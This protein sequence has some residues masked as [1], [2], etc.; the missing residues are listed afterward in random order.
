MPAPSLSD[1]VLREALV[2]FHRHDGNKA[3]A[4]E[5]LGLPWQTL[6]DRVTRAQARR[7]SLVEAEELPDE[8]IPIEDVKEMMKSR[9]E[10]RWDHHK[11]KRWRKIQVHCDGP[12]G[13]MLFG[14][15][16][17]DDD[18]CNWPL[19]DDHIRLCHQP[20]IFGVNIGDTHNNWIGRLEKKYG[21]Q[22]SSKK[23]AYRLAEWLMKDAGI[24]WALWLLG[25][26][27]VWNEGARILQAMN[28]TGIAMADWG[29]QVAL[30]L[31]SGKEVRLWASHDFHGHSQWNSLHGPQKA[32]HMKDP[33]HIYACGH[34]H[35]WALHQEE[36]AS[37]A[38]TYWLARCRGYK[39]IDDYGEKLGHMPQHEGASILAVINPDS[40]TGAGFVQCYA[41]PE[42]G[43]EYLRWLR[44]RN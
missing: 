42:E 28:T 11:A 9:F 1:D 6:S 38:F 3:A 8:D 39:F 13:L 25:N 17:V 5:E 16:H 4:A 32:A 40:K 35:N 7:I 23:T 33:A 19:L 15:P 43:A 22:E 34:K 24:D 26:H 27:D 2:A 31:P 41:D 36:S 10:K 21:D 12:I 20:G 29:A 44:S 18:G 37:K 30:Q 14:D